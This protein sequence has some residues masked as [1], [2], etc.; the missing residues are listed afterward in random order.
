MK[1]RPTPALVLLP[2][3][4]ALSACGNKGPLVLPDEDDASAYAAPATDAATTVDPDVPRDEET[5][6]EDRIE[7]D[8]RDRGRD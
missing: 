7:D 6:P 8:P 5:D 2:L 4:L 3:L 1:T